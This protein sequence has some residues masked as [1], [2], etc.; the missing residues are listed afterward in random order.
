MIQEMVQENM[1]ELLYNL[2]VRK[3]FLTVAHNLDTIL[4]RLINLTI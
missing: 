2:H 1:D 3:G 4:K